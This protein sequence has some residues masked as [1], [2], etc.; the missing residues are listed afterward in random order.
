MNKNWKD[1]PSRWFNL[2]NFFT[3]SMWAVSI[4]SWKQMKI[5]FVLRKPPQLFGKIIDF[6]EETMENFRVY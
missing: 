4:V 5:E 6:P 3:I 1:I 2:D